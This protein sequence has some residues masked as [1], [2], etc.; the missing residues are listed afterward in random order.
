MW[1]TPIYV[2]VLCPGHPP[3]IHLL[4]KEEQ[5]AAWA[6]RRYVEDRRQVYPIAE[7]LFDL[8]GPIRI[9]GV[10]F[11][12]EQRSIGFVNDLDEPEDVPFWW[13]RK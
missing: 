11:E 5:E 6:R 12:N 2:L 8:S 4:P 10:K 9:S 1:G 3:A 7:R 13:R